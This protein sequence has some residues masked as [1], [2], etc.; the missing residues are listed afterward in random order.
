M[1]ALRPRTLFAASFVV[2]VAACSKKPAE[3]R[4][5]AVPRKEDGGPPRF[6]FSSRW[7]VSKIGNPGDSLGSCQ[8]L[9]E[10]SCSTGPDTGSGRATCNPPSPEAIACPPGA[11]GGVRIGQKDYADPDCWLL[12]PGCEYTDCVTQ[13]VRC[14]WTWQ[15][16]AQLQRSGSRYDD[17]RCVVDWPSPTNSTRRFVVPCP[18]PAATRFTIRRGDFDQPCFA[19]G[20]GFERHEVPCPEEPRTFD[21]VAAFEQAYRAD[22]GA[23]AGKRVLVPGFYL[24]DRTKPRGSGFAVTI[25]ATRTGDAPVFT[26]SIPKALM[27][28]AVTESVIADGHVT[29]GPGGL[30]LDD[31]VIWSY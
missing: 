11:E 25:A 8:A 9:R 17:A 12:P 28:T 30:A 6:G 29:G 24:P 14:P 26:C 31:C 13:K 20:D 2:T 15:E 19:E 18:A 7:K 5:E 27:A 22:S 23:F 16:L 3:P 21:T 10:I 1:P 4:K